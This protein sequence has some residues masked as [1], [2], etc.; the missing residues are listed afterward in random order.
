MDGLLKYHIEN[1]D[2]RL[3]DLQVE[4][5]EIRKRIDSLQEFKVSMIAGA[6]LTS[7]LV[8]SLC[9]FITLLV[10]IYLAK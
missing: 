7:L 1:T 3:S 9:G 4:T 10:T 6:R 2:K 8:S 5:R